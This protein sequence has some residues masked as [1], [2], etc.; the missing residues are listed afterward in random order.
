MAI[1]T[2]IALHAL[3]GLPFESN[4]SIQDFSNYTILGILP[5]N[6]S[7]L[8][9]SCLYVCKLSRA[10]EYNAQNPGCHFFCIKDCATDKIQ[11]KGMVMI[12][13]PVTVEELFTRLN[14]CFSNIM[15]WTNAL[16]NAVLGGSD[17]QYLLNIAEPIL[18]NVLIVMDSSFSVIA[19]TKNTDTDDPI[20]SQLL[21]RGFHSSEVLQGFRKAGLF[22]SYAQTKDILVYEGGI[23][24]QKATAGRWFRHHGVPIIGLVMVD[25]DLK[26]ELYLLDLFRIFT[27]A[28]AYCFQ[29]R[30][31][32]YPEYRNI[33]EPFILDILYNEVSDP[34]VICERA[35]CVNINFRG[36]F[37]V[38]K[39][40]FQDSSRMAVGRVKQN[41]ASVL[42]SARIV[43]HGFEIAVLN[44]FKTEDEA[45]NDRGPDSIRPLL[46]Q[47]GVS[48]GVSRSFYTLTDLRI[49][50]LQA[51][52]AISMGERLLQAEN[53]S[54]LTDE[55][56]KKLSPL[57]DRFVF[58]YQ[59]MAIYQFIENS[60]RSSFDLF[61]LDPYVR[62]LE[63]LREYDHR[64]NEIYMRILYTYLILERR[65]TETAAT[66]NIHRGSLLYHI[67][68]I[69]SIIKNSLDDP[70]VRL[71][72]LLAYRYLE[73]KS[74]DV[75]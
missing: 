22:D 32:L 56:R 28:F 3:E 16:Q 54:N 36:F 2:A 46:Q 42:P 75:L 66:I 60:R 51:S 61:Q 31:Q 24:T 64:K 5:P 44:E 1:T 53:I 19:H 23:I 52:S 59:D 65:A 14:T 20:T 45:K 13:P 18:Q 40:S 71:G 68:K 73:L 48:C 8:S 21:Q 57:D 38:Y 39:L 17:Y 26:I 7:M 41:L 15:N 62:T 67:E 27:N 50:F 4:I 63:E 29:R 72:L 6:P 49:S 34:A 58:R 47:F 37:N 11:T 33:Y 74:T 12:E 35:K 25:R 55:L 30:Q 43:S 69:Q 70:E 9:S 10:L